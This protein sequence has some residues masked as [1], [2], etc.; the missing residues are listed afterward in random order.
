MMKQ[1]IFL[2]CLLGLGSIHAQ[3]ERVFV[4]TDKSLY[5]SGETI[6]LAAYCLDGQSL[7]PSDYSKVLYVELLN[8]DAEPVLQQKLSLDQGLGRGQLFVE[9]E[10]S[11]G[12]YYLKAY[13]R[14]MRNAGPESFFEA[15]IRVVHPFRLADPSLGERQGSSITPETATPNLKISTDQETYSTRTE[16]QIDIATLEGIKAAQLSVSVH[17]IDSNVPQ[18][19]LALAS[20]LSSAASVEGEFAGEILAPS[21]QG[22]IQTAT[23]KVFV[24]FPGD[25]ARLFAVDKDKQGDF[26]LL[27]PPELAQKDMLFWA[28]DESGIEIKLASEFAEG[29]QILRPQDWEIDS[30]ALP[31]LQSLSR[32]AQINNAFLNYSEVRGRK[33]E[34]LADAYFYG[35]PDWVY[36][37]DD[38]TR[39]PVMEEIFLE[40][41]N[42]VHRRKRRTDK[43]YLDVNDLYANENSISSSIHFEDP[44]LVMID[45]IPIQKM[46]FLWEFDPLL[47][48]RVE[49][50]GRKYYAGP[51]TFYGV[52]N[53]VTYKHNFGGLPFPEYVVEQKYLPLQLPRSFQS[54]NYAETEQARI[55]DYRSLLY[56]E[57][58]LRWNGKS[59]QRSCY[60]SDDTGR[61][62]VVINGISEDGQALYGTTTFSVK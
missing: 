56:W 61:Y 12:L 28:E 14:A 58:H 37:L 54:P 9:G 27:L 47:V 2:L 23:D 41:L 36:F 45:G 53:L 1:L 3:S 19:S 57:A 22:N 52:V 39:F 38:Y 15:P 34:P 51:H 24:L 4:Q 33:A 13:T 7:L 30:A 26:S 8:A 49:I 18:T 59:V 10:L 50:V 16:V 17:K 5:L 31:Y 11:T 35:E 48:E 60:T 55:P 20:G 42:Y 43:E 44:A 62:R 21:L 32:N 25:N 46:S 6:W 29:H 40:I